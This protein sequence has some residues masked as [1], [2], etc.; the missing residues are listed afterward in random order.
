MTRR[1]S[2]DTFTV[3]ERSRIMRA[4][5]AKG[6]KAEAD[7]LRLLRRLGLRFQAHPDDLQGRPDFV[8]ARL[9]VAI[10]VDGDFWHGRWWRRGGKLPVANRSYWV[11]KLKRNVARDRRTDR[12][13]RRRGWSVLRIWESDIQ[14]D[15]A[16]VLNLLRG[17]L[18]RRR[19]DS[20]SR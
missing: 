15:P 7:A 18:A 17:R 4:V 16:S 12:L 5:K 8:N 19:R 9:R 13:L 10:F 1:K 6:T 14:R 20:R 11:A 2:S 3:D